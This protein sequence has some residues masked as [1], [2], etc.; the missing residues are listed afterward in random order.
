MVFITGLPASG[1][2]FLMREQISMAVAAGRRVHIMRWDAGLASFETDSILAR[3]P[4]AEDGSHPVIR[5]AAG[6]WA[7][8]VLARW[9]AER[10]DP[11]DMLIGE[12]PII[13]NRYSEFVQVLPD[14]VEKTLASDDTAFFYPVPTRE[15]RERLEAIRRTTYANPQHP[16]EARDAPP[17]TMELAWQLTCEKAVGLGLASPKDIKAQS[18]Y[19]ESIYRRFFN[20]LLRH[21]TACAINIETLYPGGRS[22]HDLDESVSELVATPA[23][24]ADAIAAVEAAMSPEKAAQEVEN[25]FLPQNLGNGPFVR[26]PDHE[27]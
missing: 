9:L 13:G 8:Q 16:D 23:E 5:K 11:A 7:R 15:V 2:S 14:S 21:R 22:A 20:H 24:V 19:D 27:G 12:V 25:W 1:K 18:T 6:L 3:Y 10:L 4:D 17:A 26:K